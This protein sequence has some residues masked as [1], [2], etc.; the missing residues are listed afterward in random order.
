M[1]HNLERKVTQDKEKG[2]LDRMQFDTISILM[3]D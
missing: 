2:S 1:K 3:T